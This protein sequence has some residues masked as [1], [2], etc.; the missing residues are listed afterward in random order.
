MDKYFNRANYNYVLYICEKI[1]MNEK[2]I[3]IINILKENDMIIIKS[4]IGGIIF[5]IIINIIIN[6]YNKKTKKYV[7]N[8]N[9]LNITLIGPPQS[10]K[11]SYLSRLLNLNNQNYVLKGGHVTTRDIYFKKI[12]L[13]TN[14]GE[15]RINVFDTPGESLFTNEINPFIRLSDG[16]IIM[17]PVDLR[18]QSVKEIVEKVKQSSCKNSELPIISLCANKIDLHSLPSRNAKIQNWYYKGKIKSF[19]ISL[20][21]NEEIIKNIGTFVSN[22]FT[23]KPHML[24]NNTIIRPIEYILS[25]RMD[26]QVIYNRNNIIKIDY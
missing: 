21:Q 14:I 6:I 25:K 5:T 20:K 19:M 16:V 8:I 3:Y 4:L 22:L 18:D 10:G 1:Y 2:C 7:N 26:T 23:R 15:V 13:P 17:F 24:V 9:D 12:T 11:T